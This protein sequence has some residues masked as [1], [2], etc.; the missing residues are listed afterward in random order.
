METIR[1]EVGL[2][3]AAIWSSASDRPV[4]HNSIYLAAKIR[5]IC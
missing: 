3:E 2:E 5:N 1:R 4:K